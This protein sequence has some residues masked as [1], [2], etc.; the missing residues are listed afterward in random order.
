MKTWKY[1][2]TIL[3]TYLRLKM[4]LYVILEKKALLL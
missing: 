1:F 4:P 3:E 2:K